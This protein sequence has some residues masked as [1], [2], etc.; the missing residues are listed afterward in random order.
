LHVGGRVVDVA[1]TPGHASHH[2]SYFNSETG[3]AF[4]GDTAGL[5]TQP[6]NLVLLPTPPPDIDLP[7]WRESLTTI[8]RWNPET[9]LL[10]HFGPA[11]PAMLH[12]QEV[13]EAIDRAERLFT[14]SLEHGADDAAHEVWFIEE[15]RRVL[16]QRMTDAEAMSYEVGGRFDLSWKGLAR[17]YAKR[18]K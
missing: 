12:I 11:S 8:A 7:L 17:Y 16:R 4:V 13:F 5:M 15:V 1:Y 3:I 10:T 18:G 14:R 9:V 6:N 2:V